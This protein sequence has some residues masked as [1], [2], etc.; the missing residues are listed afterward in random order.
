VCETKPFLPCV[1]A[2]GRCVL[3]LLFL[4]CGDDEGEGGTPGISNLFFGPDSEIVHLRGEW[5]G[6]TVSMDYS[7]PDGDP[8][9]VRM[10]FRYCGEGE[11]RHEDIAPV[12]IT[13]DE[14]GEIWIST[15]VPASCPAGAYLYEF[16]LFD[17]KGNESNTL[18]ATLT[19]TPLLGTGP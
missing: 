6:V 5:V 15:E 12:G 9:F 11:M 18:E 17:Q 2:I 8:A 7:D 10:R 19:L 4:G 16:S 1:L 13:G 14:E 3:L